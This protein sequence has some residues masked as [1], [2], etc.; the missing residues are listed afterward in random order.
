MA[1]SLFNG[2]LASNY[3]YASLFN[4]I[5]SQ[6]VFANNI[7]GTYAELV[8]AA[9]VDG[10]LYGDR[11]LY[12]STDVLRTHAW[13]AYAE[14][15]N[16]LAIDKAPRPKTQEIVLDN[17]R[18]IRLTTDEY[19]SKQAWMG[20]GAFSQFTG[21][22]MAWMGD[23]K[24][25]Y[26]STLYNATFGTTEAEAS[27][28]EITI[29][30][31]KEPAANASDVEIEA[32]NRLCAQAIATK[33]ADLKVR[34][35][36]VSRDFNDYGFLR[37]YNPDSLKV[38]FNADTANKIRFNDLPTIF[39]KDA[40][41]I[42]GLEDV[43]PARYF[44]TV[45]ATGGTSDGNVRTLVEMELNVD[46]QGK[47]LAMDDAAYDVKKHLFPGDV[48]PSGVAYAAGEA[49]DVDP[50]IAFKIVATDSMPYMSA[51]QVST[52]FFN[53]RSLTTNH[54][55]TYGH[56]TLQHLYDRPFITVKVVNA[57]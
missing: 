39:H 27:T 30:L 18:Q 13:G 24:R 47:P 14:A 2:Q 54:Y 37:S 19:L 6:Q 11:K 36:D 22:L 16:L 3:I 46:G 31:P 21:V 38:V 42:K 4:M 32:Y 23:T 17:F 26:D 20:E 55:L 29:T 44:G 10:T 28:Q 8:D 34:L 7:N 43:L 5:I 49:Y 35:K 33:M 52:S 51:F 12:T 9:K 57:Q 15:T 1:V 45:K 56:N 48:I 50:T 53:A 41:T 25:V 40:V